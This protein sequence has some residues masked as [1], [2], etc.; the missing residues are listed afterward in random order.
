MKR[1]VNEAKEPNDNVR[2]RR[3]PIM[4]IVSI[5]ALSAVLACAVPT[6]TESYYKLPNIERIGTNLYQSTKVIVETRSCV[7][8]PVDDEDA[9]LKYVGQEKYEIVFEDLSTCEVQRVTFGETLPI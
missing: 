1:A 3:F 4:R 7:H 5:L 8:H 9:L 6:K 2:G